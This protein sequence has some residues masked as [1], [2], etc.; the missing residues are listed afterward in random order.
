MCKLLLRKYKIIVHALII[1]TL[2]GKIT[3]VT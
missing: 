2:D 1:E 3:K